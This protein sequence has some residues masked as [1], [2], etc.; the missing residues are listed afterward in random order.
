MVASRLSSRKSTEQEK[1][2]IDS[3]LRSYWRFSSSLAMRAR[4]LSSAVL[5]ASRPISRSRAAQRRSSET[6]WPA[7]VRAP[8]PLTLFDL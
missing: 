6:T 2:R 3:G 1:P 8:E 7:S 4:A 5:K